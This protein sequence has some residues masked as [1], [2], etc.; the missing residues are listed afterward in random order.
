M[1]NIEAEKLEQL[2]KI[3]NERGRYIKSEYPLVMYHGFM[4]CWNLVKPWLMKSEPTDEPS[5]ATDAK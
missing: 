4:E 1:K 5:V 3:V 2:E